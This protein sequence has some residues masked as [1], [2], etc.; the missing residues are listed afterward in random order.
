MIFQMMILLKIFIIKN[1]KGYTA[2]DANNEFL[3]RLFLNSN[4]IFS[5]KGTKQAIE[6]LMGVFGFHSQDWYDKYIKI[7][8]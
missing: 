1:V 5:K 8:L 3:R 6:D 2:S 4:N 7:S